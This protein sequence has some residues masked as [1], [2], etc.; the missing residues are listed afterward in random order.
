MMRHR[1]VALKKNMRHLCSMPKS[2]HSRFVSAA[3]NVRGQAVP[4]RLRDIERVGFA[5]LNDTCQELIIEQRV[6]GHSF[7][8]GTRR[9]PFERQ[10]EALRILSKS[11]EF[12]R[13][14]AYQAH[15]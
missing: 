10:V 3:G 1:C 9:R 13:G 5:R 11:T 8:H 4:G 14:A 7:D 15:N 6:I 12:S 2:S